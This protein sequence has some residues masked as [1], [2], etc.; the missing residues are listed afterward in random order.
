MLE[1]QVEVGNA[2]GADGV[3]QG[4]VEVRRVQVQQAGACGACRHGLDQRH[5]ATLA[6]A[7]VAAV[8]G[9]VLGHQHDFD[10]FELLDLREDLLERAAALGTAEAGDGAEAA[11]AVASLGDLHVCPRAGRRWPG[12][13]Q[14]VERRNRACAPP[15]QLH[16]HPAG[17][18][19][20]RHLRECHPESGDA[21]GLRQGLGQFVAVALRETA[22]HHQRSAGRFGLREGQDRVDRLLSGI[23]HEGAGV[24]DHH[25][26]LGRLAR[27][28]QAVGNQQSNKLVGVNLVLGA[29]QG[30]H[31]ERSG[32]VGHRRCDQPRTRPCRLAGAA[33]WLS[34]AA[35][36]CED[37]SRPR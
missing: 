29:P 33:R 11:G 36:A 26:G 21:V 19:R 18:G 2:R 24:Y 7:L 27:R 22:G 15:A 3:D 25:V 9:E 1:R 6:A 37:R 34:W 16:W 13:V 28:R 5:D 31:H 32:P 17:L 10:R 4:V 20:R 23:L 35:G 14:Q 8:G 30:V 12:Q